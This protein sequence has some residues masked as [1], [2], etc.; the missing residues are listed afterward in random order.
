MF[1]VQCGGRMSSVTEVTCSKLANT[2]IVSMMEENEATNSQ[3]VTKPQSCSDTDY[4]SL[5]KTVSHRWRWMQFSA[6]NVINQVLLVCHQNG[7][8]RECQS[9]DCQLRC[10]MLSGL[11][12]RCILNTGLMFIFVC[13]C[14]FLS[15]ATLMFTFLCCLILM[16][17]FVPRVSSAIIISI[18]VPVGP[19]TLLLS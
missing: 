19:A 5:L 2:Y 17:P 7:Q 4:T 10:L 9:I 14:C 1:L 16:V 3:T 8:L 18:T 11:R 6:F 12:F 13:F 15:Y